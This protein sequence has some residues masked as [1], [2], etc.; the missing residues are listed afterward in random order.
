[1]ELPLSSII[2]AWVAA[3]LT[4]FIYSFLYRENP[5][6]KIAEHLYLGVS[7]G[8]AFCILLFN[9]WF[10]KIQGPVLVGDWTPV[11]PSLLGLTLLTRLHPKHSWVS[12]FGFAFIMGYASGVA[13]PAVLTTMFLKQI[14]GTIVPVFRLTAS[15]GLDL[16]GGALWDSFSVLLLAAGCVAVL[17][18]FFF[19]V[20]HKGP[21][22]KVPVIG[23][24]FLMVYL[25]ASFG[26]TVMSRFSLLYGRFYDMYAYSSA[27]YRYATP[28]LL[29]AVVAFLV[30]FTVKFRRKE[31]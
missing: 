16:S 1:M 28:A 31:I 30:Y 11:L 27:Q 21:L 25:G 17:F 8:Y 18:Y 26:V 6:F 13:I 15:G 20:E 23:I 24:Y 7:V 5:L 29:C 4:L 19:S 3:G 22:K 10:P 2:G 14:Q 9:V 12:R